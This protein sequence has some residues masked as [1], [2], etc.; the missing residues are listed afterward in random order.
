MSPRYLSPPPPPARVNLDAPSLS[1]VPSLHPQNVAPSRSSCTRTR[2]RWREGASEVT[3]PAS[4][5]TKRMTDWAWRGGVARSRFTIEEWISIADCF[6]F[7]GG[8]RYAL[9]GGL[10]QR[11]DGRDRAALFRRATDPTPFHRSQLGMAPPW[12]RARARV[13]V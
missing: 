1:F 8:D 13:C 4:C 9:S 10:Q 12:P 6:V 3:H 11:E 7:Q 2:P 5:S